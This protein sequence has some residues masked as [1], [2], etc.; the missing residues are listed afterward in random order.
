MTRQ[1]KRADGSPVDENNVPAHCYTNPSESIN[2]VMSEQ[3]NLAG[4]KKKQDVTKLQFILDV[5]EP[6]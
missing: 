1:K 6:A 2:H 5:Y 3:N 4:Y